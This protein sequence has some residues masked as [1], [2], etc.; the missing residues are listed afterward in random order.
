MPATVRAVPV[1]LSQAGVAVAA[2]LTD[3]DLGAR[4]SATRRI[5]F[6]LADRGAFFGRE[7]PAISTDGGQSWQIDGPLLYRAAAGGGGAVGRL[8]ATAPRWAYAWGQL[9]DRVL[10]THDGGATWLSAELA[11]GIWRV[12][13]VGR[14]LW[15]R[16]LGQP[17]PGGGPG[18]E[19]FL[20]VSHDYG[21]SWTLRRQLPNID[22]SSAEGTR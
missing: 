11:G 17:T 3:R 21:L 7:Y 4:A 14:T 2:P 13:S 12:E 20:Y 1:R 22:L 19:S 8:G 6:G 9:G 16:A 18:F 10:V 15:A 5:I